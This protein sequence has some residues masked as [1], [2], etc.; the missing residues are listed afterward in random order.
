MTERSFLGYWYRGV[1]IAAGVVLAV[2][3]LLL[4]IIATARSILHNA[5]RANTLVKEIVTNTGAVWDLAQTNV[6]AGQLLEGAA[7]IAGH[8]TAVADAL[9]APKPPA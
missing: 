2:A 5:E 1:A 6:V 3:A 9:D 4:A 7:S 8:A